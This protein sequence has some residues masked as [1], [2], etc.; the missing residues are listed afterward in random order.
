[1]EVIGQCAFS[2]CR[3]LKNIDFPKSLQR[4]DRHAFSRCSSLDISVYVDFIVEKWAFYMANLN[5]VIVEGGKISEHSFRFASVKKITIKRDCSISEHSFCRTNVEQM[6]CYR[7]FIPYACFYQCDKLKK[8]NIVG[9]CTI[10]E[11]CFAGCTMLEKVHMGNDTQFCNSSFSSTFLETIDFPL[12]YNIPDF[13]FSDNSHLVKL[14]VPG[15]VEYI[16]SQAFKGCSKLKEIVFNEGLMSI[17]DSAFWKCFSLEKLVFPK[18]LKRIDGC[19]FEGC[20]ALK[21]IVFL[22]IETIYNNTSFLE[23][24]PDLEIIYPSIFENIFDSD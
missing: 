12:P 23:T 17:H 8:I 22:G 11:K 5:E 18:S 2:S 10:G 21:E 1:L 4:I 7:S 24:H 9:D 16:Y 14:V 13:C 15:N 3:S 20:S 19:A 6:I